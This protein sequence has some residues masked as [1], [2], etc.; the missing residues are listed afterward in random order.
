M[1]IGGKC[2]NLQTYASQN[3]PSGTIKDAFNN[4]ISPIMTL[5]TSFRTICFGDFTGINNLLHILYYY[6]KL[7]FIRIFLIFKFL[8]KFQIGSDYTS[9]N[10]YLDQTLC[11]VMP[12]ASS[13]IYGGVSFAAGKLNC[14]D[15]DIASCFVF[16][17]CGTFAFSLSGGVV[18]C[19][20]SL[21]GVGNSL[22]L[23]ADITEH[24]TLGF[25]WNAR[26]HHEVEIASLTGNEFGFKIFGINS[27]LIISFG[28]ALPSNMTKAGKIISKFLSIS[29]TFERFVCF[30]D[31]TQ[32]DSLFTAIKSSS[33]SSV[34]QASIDAFTSLAGVNGYKISG[35]A[36]ILLA[37]LTYNF[38]QD[39]VL[40][41]PNIYSVVA[42]TNTIGI[43][44]GIYYSVVYN[45]GDVLKTALENVYAHFEGIF[46]ALG[47]SLFSFSGLSHLIAK[48]GVFVGILKAGFSIIFTGFKLNCVFDLTAFRGS[49]N[50]DTVFFTCILEGVVWVFK[51]ATA[52]FE[53]TGEEIA[54]I[55]K[56]AV[57]YSKAIVKPGI[58]AVKKVG[59]KISA[60]LFGKICK[61]NS[62]PSF[63]AGDGSIFR[64]KKDDNND[65]Q[66]G[67]A[68]A[69]ATDDSSSS[70][71]ITAEQ[72]TDSNVWRQLWEYTGD[73]KICNVMID[74]NM[75]GDKSVE[76]NKKCITGD[77]G[78]KNIR[79]D[80]YANAIAFEVNKV[81]NHR[82][83]FM[84][85]DKGT[86]DNCKNASP[87][88]AI[89][90]LESDG[91]YTS[92]NS[93]SSFLDFDYNK[94][95]DY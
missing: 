86:R 83:K 75:Y 10:Q 61:K 92:L 69:C 2:Y 30:S 89:Y 74:N 1:G 13:S 52:F 45:I 19:L 21:S 73:H 34:I 25:S 54:R 88:Y 48:V 5:F 81:D 77:S 14:S 84:M 55:A 79:L 27:N 8:T 24:I 35:S 29:G 65:K 33:V 4:L 6:F 44:E 16:D 47:F 7:L 63:R 37:D 90:F 82:F 85:C 18:G 20:S 71:V 17:Q 32:L 3:L 76:D 78:W 12:L 49:C 39:F 70:C 28:A 46:D 51:K 58:K 42:G 62:N 91:S 41:L 40:D 87:K 50:R 53:E 31:I 68:A 93:H 95:E 60:A 59:C 26:F 66:L 23:A 57:H 38:L 56:T 11:S 36:S 15:A 80:T 72:N 64:F 94:V 43:D 9:D 67:V 22:R